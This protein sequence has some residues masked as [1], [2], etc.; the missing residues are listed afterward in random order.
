MLPKT[1]LQWEM[2]SKQLLAA[3][4]TE[5]E[6][7][8]RLTR[9]TLLPKFVVLQKIINTFYSRAISQWRA[10]TKRVEK[11]VADGDV[12][13]VR[14]VARSLAGRAI[15]VERHAENCHHVNEAIRLMSKR[16]KD[17]QA[18]AAHLRQIQL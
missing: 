2:S 17:S 6:G 3:L 8:E 5:M 10:D 14:L 13:E 1:D 9:K 11:G 15:D 12:L 18:I 7:R 4:R 16:K